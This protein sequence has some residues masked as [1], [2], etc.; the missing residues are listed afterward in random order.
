MMDWMVNHAGH[1]DTKRSHT[2]GRS[3]ECAGDELQMSNSPGD[4][5][6]SKGVSYTNN[7]TDLFQR[8]DKERWMFI[9][10]VFISFTD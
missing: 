7:I 6:Q 5:K 2:K 3:E 8:M 1:L 9:A 10:W 4:R